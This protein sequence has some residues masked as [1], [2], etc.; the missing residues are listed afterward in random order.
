MTNSN[1]IYGKAKLK[2]TKT[3]NL[4]IA[5][6]P[7]K[8]SRKTKVAGMSGEIFESASRAGF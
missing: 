1:I 5:D 2:P 4:A 3:D 6:H 7:S 8:T